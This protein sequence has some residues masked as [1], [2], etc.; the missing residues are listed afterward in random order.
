MKSSFFHPQ[1]LQAAAVAL[2]LLSA[3][4]CK[5]AIPEMTLDCEESVSFDSAGGPGVVRFT[6]YENWK[7]RSSVSW[8]T[9]STTGGLPNGERISVS[10][11]VMENGGD[12]ERTAQITITSGAVSK[13]VNVTQGKKH[14]ITAGSTRV[15]IDDLGQT[16]TIKVKSNVDYDVDFG[17]A[18][19]LR[20]IENKALTESELT[21]GADANPETEARSAYVT[22]KDRSSAGSIRIEVFQSGA[23]I[24][25]ACSACGLYDNTKGLIVPEGMVQQ[26]VIGDSDS[27]SFHLVDSKERRYCLFK[28]IPAAVREMKA[29]ESFTLEIEHNYES[30]PESTLTLNPEVLKREGDLLWAWDRSARKGIIIKIR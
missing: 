20:L 11:N 29:G 4:S 10:Y 14:I 7:V 15:N 13:T 23:P 12:E 25:S 16:F 18:R 3:V 17:D 19:W 6:P 24:I 1:L 2:A 28:G 5:Q 21:I 22:L 30:I 27:F 8:L 26:G 9:L